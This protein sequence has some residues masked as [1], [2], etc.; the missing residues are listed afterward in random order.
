[1]R[2]PRPLAVDHR[3]S[4]SWAGADPPRGQ[5]FVVGCDWTKVPYRKGLTS[6]ASL[7]KSGVQAQP[8]S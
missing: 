3:Q 7:R 2:S 1:M 8:T 5:H 6:R 4:G